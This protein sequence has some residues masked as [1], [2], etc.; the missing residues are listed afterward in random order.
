MGMKQTKSIEELYPI[1]E[2][3]DGDPFPRDKKPE[4]PKPP[5]VKPVPKITLGI[6]DLKNKRIATYERRH[7][8]ALCEVALALKE[9]GHPL[10][11]KLR[12]ATREILLMH[13]ARNEL[14]ALD[15]YKQGGIAGNT[16]T[17]V[18]L[19]DLEEKRAE[20][21]KK[22]GHDKWKA[23]AIRRLKAE[24]KPISRKTLDKQWDKKDEE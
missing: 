1:I 7:M 24:G 10:A 18:T 16:R 14:I 13:D 5:L 4:E 9:E 22:T 20:H 21:F 6:T 3:G 17:K 12:M 15:S 2:E 8:E 23:Y 19:Q 11:N